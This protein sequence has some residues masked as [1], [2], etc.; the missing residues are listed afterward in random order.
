MRILMHNHTFFSQMA[1][2]GCNFWVIFYGEFIPIIKN[3]IERKK[4]ARTQALLGIFY[5][6]YIFLGTC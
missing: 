6:T 3:A 5:E 1:G 2:Y 4:Y